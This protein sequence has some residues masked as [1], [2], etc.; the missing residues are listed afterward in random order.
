MAKASDYRFI[1]F[2]RQPGLWRA[3]MTPVVPPATIARGAA[4][5]GFMTAEDSKSAADAVLAA[6][7]TIRELDAQANRRDFGDLVASLAAECLDEA[8]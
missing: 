2:Q 1:T 8:Q 7:R 6:N 5:R 4:L 3:N